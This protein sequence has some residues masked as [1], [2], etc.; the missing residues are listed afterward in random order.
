MGGICFGNEI[1]AEG[2]QMASQPGNGNFVGG[3][4]VITRDPGGF[5]GPAFS[6][7]PH[8]PS[9]TRSRW[10]CLQ[11]LL[12]SVPSSP[13][14]VVPFVHTLSI[15]KPQRWLPCLQSGPL[16]FISQTTKW[17]YQTWTW[18]WSTPTC[19]FLASPLPVFSFCTTYANV[20][21]VP[22]AVPASSTLCAL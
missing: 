2:W 10:F 7:T 1:W 16:H 11:N 13:H 6:L 3:R 9:V 21:I 19:L 8:I 12:A 22:W 5:L 18:S 14:P 17:S 4:F 15:S 20:H